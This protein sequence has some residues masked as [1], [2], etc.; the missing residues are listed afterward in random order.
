MSYTMDS[1]Q[2]VAGLT[3][4]NVQSILH[5]EGG[6][7]STINYFISFHF[8]SYFNFHTAFTNAAIE[9]LIE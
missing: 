8:Y 6:G 1:H 2:S 7:L 3:Q 9:K 4:R 5:R